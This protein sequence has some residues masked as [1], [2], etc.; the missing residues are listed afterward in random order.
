MKKPPRLVATYHALPFED[1][2]TY[3]VGLVHPG[4]IAVLRIK[5]LMKYRYPK[6]LRP[7]RRNHT[8]FVFHFVKR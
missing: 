4:F 6:V 8:P 1:E 7:G 2:E 3:G 5:G